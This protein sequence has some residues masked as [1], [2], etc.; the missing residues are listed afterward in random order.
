MFRKKFLNMII[1]IILRQILKSANFTLNILWNESYKPR[2]EVLEIIRLV[3]KFKT[4][5][6]LSLK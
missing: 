4:Y 1:Y 2:N 5:N 6:V 3:T